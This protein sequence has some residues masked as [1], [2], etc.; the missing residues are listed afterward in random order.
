MTKSLKNAKWE[1]KKKFTIKTLVLQ[2]TFSCT[3]AASWYL[4][5]VWSIVETYA[6]SF[7]FPSP[8]HNR[9]IFKRD[10]PI[11][12][13]IHTTNLRS[14]CERLNTHTHIYLF[15][16]YVVVVVRILIFLLSRRCHRPPPRDDSS[17]SGVVLSRWSDPRAV[18]G[19]RLCFSRGKPFA[20][21]HWCQKCTPEILY[22][23]ASFYFFAFFHYYTNADAS[24]NSCVRIYVFIHTP[25][26]VCTPQHSVDRG[27]RIYSGDF[28]ISVY[29]YAHER[30]AFD[31]LP[32][33]INSGIA[34]K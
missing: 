7:K 21:R 33:A 3:F 1:W 26:S 6:N 4:A 20:H 15:M 13:Y 23:F 17:C 22:F 24:L 16:Y 18:D 25:R 12:F 8:I 32:F 14:Y 34:K 5:K 10:D 2:N 9:I 31:A 19:L 11:F 28:K 29:V 27:I 30:R